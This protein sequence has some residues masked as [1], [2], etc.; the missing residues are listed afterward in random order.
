[1]RY[2][3][4]DEARLPRV[5]ED[6]L[7][8]SRTN[9]W[10]R[11]GALSVMDY[12]ADP[13]IATFGRL[14]QD[15]FLEGRTYALPQPNPIG[16]E[17]GES[18]LRRRSVRLFTGDSMSASDLAALLIYTAGVTGEAEVPLTT[19][20]HEKYYFRA[21]PSGGGLYPVEL[22]VAVINVN[23]LPKGVYRYSPRRNVLVEHGRAMSV[24]ELAASISTPDDQLNTRG[25]AAILLFGATPWRS[26]R[27]YGPRG[28]RF[29]F[30]E[31]GAMS[32]HVHLI[33]TSLG[34]GSTD[35]SSFYDDK[36]NL[37][38]GFDG[39]FRFLAHMAVVGWPA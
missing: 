16:M 30:H 18:V 29:V 8:A 36:A 1:M 27:K 7:V 28:L 13:M 31:A 15:S 38:L 19:G 26:M 10:D 25:A 4:I 24:D 22:Y 34:L 12:F 21:A 23:G 37:A 3:N 20:A 33:S 32:E 14:D 35:C 5:A 9:E 2:D 11:D 17:L 6:F 39:Q